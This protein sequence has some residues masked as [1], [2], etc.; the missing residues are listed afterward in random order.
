[1]IEPVADDRWTAAEELAPGV[2]W[3]IAQLST[4]ARLRISGHVPTMH[5][6]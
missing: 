6:L 2:D 3:P 4:G 5:F 1:V